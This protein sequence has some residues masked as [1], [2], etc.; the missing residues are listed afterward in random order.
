MAQQRGN[1]SGGRQRR[2]VAHIA[3]LFLFYALLAFCV[4]TFAFLYIFKWGK[5]HLVIP[6]VVLAVLV[7]VVA[8]V[9]HVK[10]GRRTRVDSFVDRGL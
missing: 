9:V 10:A 6:L 3:G 2:S 5:F 1:T 8:T 7:G 4:L